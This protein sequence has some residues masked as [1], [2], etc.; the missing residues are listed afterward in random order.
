[1]P[2]RV[3][4]LRRLS[5]LPALA[6]AALL[7]PAPAA[8]AAGHRHR[9]QQRIAATVPAIS[10]QPG[11]PDASPNTQISI[12]GIAPSRIE[13]VEVTGS[14]SGA[15]SGT[16]R[17][18]SGGQGA[19]FVPS[20]AFT[21]GETVSAAVRIKGL[22]VDRFSFTIAQLGTELPLLSVNKPQPDKLQHFYSEP[23]LVPPKIA[24]L[25]ADPKLP[26]DV[27][28]TPLPSPIVHPGTDNE[29]T[30][31]PVGPGGPMI[32]NARG[33]LVWFDQVAPPDAAANLQLQTYR[34]HQVLTWWQGGVTIAA[35]GEGEGV[36]ANSSYRTIATVHA[37]NGYPLDLHE[38]ELTPAG[39]ALVTIYS[40]VRVHLP[41]TPAPQLTQMLDAIAQEI[42]VRTGLVVWE[43]HA[44]GHIPLADSYATAANSATLDFY[45]LNSIQPIAGGHLLISARDTSAIYD[46]DQTTGQIAWTLGGKASSFKLD[47]GARFYFQHDARMLPD[48]DVSLYDDEAGPPQY[49]PDSRGLILKLNLKRRTATVARQFH[50]P[51]TASSD[52]EG[53]FQALSDGDE[54]VGFGSEPYFAQFTAGGRLEFEGQVPVD[55][56]SYRSFRFPWSATPTTKPAVFAERASG[57]IDVYASWNGATAVARWQVLAGASAASLKVVKTAADTGFETKIV[58][59]RSAAFAA[60]RALD[61]RGRVLRE[62]TP[63]AVAS[64]APYGIAPASS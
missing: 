29:L 1:M 52:S 4:P 58:V 19:S 32:I 49:A 56:G 8:V 28:L 10:P 62:S 3:V 2:V 59:G 41:G 51:Q 22:P 48:G 40:R 21:Q 7:V 23:S 42:D 12:F 30:L 35:F 54:F 18:Y 55:D 43:W 64:A 47:P 33:K 36:I 37:G 26:G 34:G 6:T 38:F 17:D 44:L 5:F 50:I 13:S 25:K 9:G 31:D 45:H 53:S 39:D 16:L 24:I 27:F 20:A 61:V 60:V 63:V 11:T 46:V 14:V 15:H 57:G